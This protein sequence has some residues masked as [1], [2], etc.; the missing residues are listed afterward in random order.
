MRLSRR[1]RVRA[2]TRSFAVA[3]SSVAVLAASATSSTSSDTALSTMD[4]DILAETAFG[5]ECFMIASGIA[6]ALRSECA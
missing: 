6:S 1:A 3:S 2:S 4:L 5:T